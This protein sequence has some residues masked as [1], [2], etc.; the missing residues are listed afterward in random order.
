MRIRERQRVQAGKAGEI[1]SKGREDAEVGQWRGQNEI[2]LGYRAGNETE[3]RDSRG[4]L[5]DEGM[6]G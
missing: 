2:Q 1:K 3:V 5:R 6:R 4:Q